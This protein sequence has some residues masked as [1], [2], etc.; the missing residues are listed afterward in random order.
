MSKYINYI[1]TPIWGGEKQDPVDS[2]ASDNDS[3]HQLSIGAPVETVNPL[4]YNLD[5]VTAYFMVLQGMI[6]TG[7]FATPASVVKSIGSIGASYVLWVAGFIIA[8]FEV[9]VYIEFVMYFKRRSGGDVV[10]LEQAYP[11][12]KFLVAT[13]Y[14][15]VTVILS[16]STSSAIAFSSYILAAADYKATAWEQRGVGVAVLT[17]VCGLSIINSRIALK[18]SN[19]LG[20]IKIVFV[21]F[22][23]ITG[24]VVLGN[25]TRVKNPTEIFKDSWK[26]STSDGN[27]I[28]SAILKVSFS[29]GGTGYVIAV[30][31]E[32]DPRKT[33]N[34]FRYFLP[35]VM[36]SVFILYILLVTAYYAGINDIKHI[37]SSGTLIAGSFFD[38]VFGTKSSKKALNVMVAFSAL[39]HLLAVVVGHSRSLR[40]CGRQGVLPYSHLWTTTKPWG[41]PVLPLVATYIVNV[42]V[43]IAPPPGDAYNFIVDIGSYSGYIFKLVLVVGLLMVR[44][45]R[46]AAGLSFEGFK[47]P[48]PI[49][50]ITILYEIFVIAMAFV[51]PTTGLIGS[52]VSFF[53]C[54]YAL[55]TIG[56][57]IVCI[58]YY[59]V[60]AKVLPKIFNYQHRTL[61]YTLENGEKGHTVVKVPIDQV[62]DWD[63]TH[64]SNGRELDVG[65]S[66]SDNIIS[67]DHGTEA[68]KK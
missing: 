34:M 55:T 10:Y 20:F 23:A 54:T 56:I 64:D 59:Y 28:S 49:L 63:A 9:L 58:I 37:K 43:L 12:P 68:G 30:A 42:I 62:E 5:Y 36:F 11:R 45:H 25:N 48:L 29:Y 46:K 1:L 7:I 41:T 8:L 4:G 47:V 2:Y 53:Y 22:I 51:P 50:I 57:L 31:G 61:Y 35:A 19:I 60:W 67:V 33:K 24:L 44:Q 18:L 38:K 3:E 39:G 13:T 40:E 6:G 21:L 32:S 16:F 52:D 27:A 15:A 66:S 14:A 26:G 65:D 17:F